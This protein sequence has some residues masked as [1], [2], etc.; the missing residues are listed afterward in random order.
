MYLLVSFILKH[1]TDFQILLIFWYRLYT[2]EYIPSQSLPR[3]WL[4]TL[5]MDTAITSEMLV[6]FYQ[7]TQKTAMLIFATMKASKFYLEKSCSVHIPLKNAIPNL[8]FP[9]KCQRLET[10]YKHWHE[11][12]VS[13]LSQRKEGCW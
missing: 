4:I 1:R 12:V 11:D 5:M 13:H 2:F 10:S 7:N 9:P 6:N 8:P 3:L